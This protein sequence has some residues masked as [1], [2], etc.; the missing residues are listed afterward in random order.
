[1]SE[2]RDRL[3]EEALALSAGAGEGGAPA[4]PL[5]F[6]GVLRRLGP[7]GP[8]AVISVTLPAVGLVTLLSLLGAVGPWLRAHEGLGIAIY[9]SGFALL[10]GLALLATWAPSIVGGWAFGFPVGYPCALAG[11]LAASLIG[12]AVGVRVSGNRV[13]EMIRERPKLRA[14]YESLLVGGFWKA[15]VLVA[16]IRLPPNTP[17]SLT[18]LVL[19]AS[20]VRLLPFALGTIIGIAPR[21]AATVLIA[22]GANELDFRRRDETW[23]FVAGVALAVVVIAIIGVWA[24]RVIS[25]VTA[26]QTIASEGE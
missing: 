9:I 1:M 4:T 22:A 19:S 23:L 13:V 11:L 7:A 3:T 16:L 25:K 24:N 2:K 26:A 21:T 8:T 5:T 12:Y 17:F 20:R 14:V 10:S 15:L 18:N 6:S